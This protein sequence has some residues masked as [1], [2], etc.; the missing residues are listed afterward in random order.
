MFKKQIS[1]KKTC[2]RERK[3]NGYL[4]TTR[5]LEHEFHSKP[6][7]DFTNTKFFAYILPEW[8]E[9]G[10]VVTPTESLGQLHDEL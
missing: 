4:Y 9:P 6:Y 1:H 2:T 7:S 10:P 8:D 5:S 3:T